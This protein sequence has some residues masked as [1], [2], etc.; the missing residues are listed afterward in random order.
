[1][2]ADHDQGTWIYKH[3]FGWRQIWSVQI[4]TVKGLLLALDGLLDGTKQAATP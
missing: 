1:M 3:A 2:D 4:Q